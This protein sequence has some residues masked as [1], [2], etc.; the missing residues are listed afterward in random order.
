MKQPAP[1][2][3]IVGTGRY[4]PDHIMTNADLEK[5]VDTNDAWI[6]ERTGIKERRIADKDVGAA[7]MGAAAARKAMEQAGVQVGEVDVIVCSTATP[8]RLLP[9]TACDIQ[10]LLGAK[11]AAAYDI[12]TACSGFLYGLQ[13]A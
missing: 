6:S 9:S 2:A 5:I 12:S 10:A 1:I 3:E 13:C 8:D 11:N 7:D 4:L